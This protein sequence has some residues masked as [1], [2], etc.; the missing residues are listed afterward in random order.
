MK[1]LIRQKRFEVIKALVESK[2]IKQEWLEDLYSILEMKD[3]NEELSNLKKEIVKFLN[4]VKISVAIPEN[5]LVLAVVEPKLL[6]DVDEKT[7]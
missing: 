2:K 1:Q 6:E 4:D 5:N 7:K 3:D